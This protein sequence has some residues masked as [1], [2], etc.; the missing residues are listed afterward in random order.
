MLELLTLFR[1]YFGQPLHG[2]GDQAVGFLYGL[3][4]LVYEAHLN[5]VPFPAELSCLIGRKQ[6]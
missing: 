4:W 1:K 2:R 6:W 5:A 3:A